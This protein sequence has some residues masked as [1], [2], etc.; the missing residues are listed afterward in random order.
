MSHLLWGSASEGKGK[1]RVQFGPEQAMEYLGFFN[2]IDL[3][4]RYHEGIL[5]GTDE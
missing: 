2:Q 3:L 5:L 1:L 4:L